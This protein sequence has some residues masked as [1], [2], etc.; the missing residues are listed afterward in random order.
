VVSRFAF[1]FNLYYLCRYAAAWSHPFRLP[2]AAA[3]DVKWMVGHQHIGGRNIRLINTTAGADDAVV[4]ES[5]AKYGTEPGVVGDEKG[6]IVDMSRCVFDPP[7]RLAGR[8]VHSSP[9]CQIGYTDQAGCH[10]LVFGVLTAKITWWKV[11]TLLA[12]GES[13]VLRSEYGADVDNFAPAAFPPPR[14]LR[15]APRDVSGNHTTHHDNNYCHSHTLSSWCNHS[16]QLECAWSQRLI[17]ESIFHLVSKVVLSNSTCYHYDEGVMGFM[18]MY[19]TVPEV[20]RC[21]LTPS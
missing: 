4:C 13:Y 17:L 16:T 2:A 5:V 6:F 7:L 19:F 20:R 18:S 3:Y 12:G 1:K 8:V 21:T 10:Q 14:P 11:P 15:H 9:G